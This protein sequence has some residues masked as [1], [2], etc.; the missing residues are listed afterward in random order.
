MKISRAATA[1]ST[2]MK[3]LVVFDHGDK[4][5]ISRVKLMTEGSESATEALT[6]TMQM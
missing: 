2:A 6:I 5:G 3:Y 1:I 4:T